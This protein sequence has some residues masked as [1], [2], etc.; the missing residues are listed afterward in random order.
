MD[1]GQGG[2]EWLLAV[3]QSPLFPLLRESK[4]GSAGCGHASSYALVR[5]SNRYFAVHFNNGP[6]KYI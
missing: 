4:M 5:A 1:L 2:R 6:E 3:L